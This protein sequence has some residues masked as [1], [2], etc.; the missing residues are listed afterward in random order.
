MRWNVSHISRLLGTDEAGHHALRKA[1][2]LG[3]LGSPGLVTDGRGTQMFGS[4]SLFRA[5]L[6]LA[7]HRAEVRG[8][9]ATSAIESASSPHA[10]AMGLGL[11]LTGAIAAVRDGHAVEFRRIVPG[12]SLPGEPL[13]HRGAPWWGNRFE[14]A[15][16]PV[17]PRAQSA[18][19]INLNRVWAPA[20]AATEEF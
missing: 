13:G 3:A 6:L 2:Q 8:Q 1:A 15:A 9:V 10:R 18:L 7:L 20:I 5:A 14:L 17:D 12:P 11:G 4:E 19:R 16:A